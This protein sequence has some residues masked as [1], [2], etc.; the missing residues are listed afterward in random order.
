MIEHLNAESDVRA[1]VITG[2][3]P[4]FF[5]VGA[6][7]N[8]LANGNREIA[9]TAATE[10]HGLRGAGATAPSR[11][12]ALRADPPYIDISI[13]V[14]VILVAGNERFR[15]GQTRITLV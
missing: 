15:S 9:R 11:L 13:N 3:G 5:S 10:D 4:K 7:L 14:F 8:T 1:I 12:A 2:D 6:D